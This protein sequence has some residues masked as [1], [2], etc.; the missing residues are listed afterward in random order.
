MT[1]MILFHG[2]MILWMV[3]VILAF[4]FLALWMGFD[5]L[6]WIWTGKSSVKSVERFVDWMF[7]VPDKIF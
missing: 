1:K 7:D 5:W 2:F 3:I 6:Y 4:P